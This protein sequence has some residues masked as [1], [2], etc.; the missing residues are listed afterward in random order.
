MIDGCVR[1]GFESVRE[2]FIENFT[3][4]GRDRTRDCE[5]IWCVF[6]KSG[7]KLGLRPCTIAEQTAPAHPSRHG[8]YDEC[9][10]NASSYPG[11]AHALRGLGEQNREAARDGARAALSRALSPQLGARLGRGLPFAGTARGILVFQTTEL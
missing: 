11:D 1:K 4:P 9:T 10:S 2:A 5:G 7:D 3:R 8:F 6:A